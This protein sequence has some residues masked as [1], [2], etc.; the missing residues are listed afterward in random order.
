MD[1]KEN[2]PESAQLWY[3]TFGQKY[4]RQPHPVLGDIPELPNCYFTVAADDLTKANRNVQKLIGRSY[5]SVYPLDGG[6]DLYYP[7]GNYGPLEDAV[8]AVKERKNDTH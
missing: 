2:P 4:F 5:S 1:E 6:Q 3:V 7:Q 8:D